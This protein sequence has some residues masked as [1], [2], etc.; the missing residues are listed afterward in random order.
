VLT[1]RLQGTGR[2][3]DRATGGHGVLLLPLS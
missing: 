2:G 3:G 1:L